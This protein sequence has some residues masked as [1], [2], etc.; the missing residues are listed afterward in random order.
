MVNT[1][2]IVTGQTKRAVQHVIEVAPN[3]RAPNTGRFGSQIQSLTNHSGFPEQFTVGRCAVL[4]Q[5]G[6]KPRQ[7]SKAE[8]TIRSN[9]LVARKGPRKIAQITP[10]QSI[11]R[12]LGL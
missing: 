8:C 9:V 12:R 6:L 10:G 1:L 3:A 11:K 4:P 7:H 2:P 5:D